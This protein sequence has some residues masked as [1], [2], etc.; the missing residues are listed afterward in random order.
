MPYFAIAYLSPGFYIKVLQE[1]KYVCA[2]THL[3]TLLSHIIFTDVMSQNN[4]FDFIFIQSCYTVP[5][6]QII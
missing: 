5:V 1:Y 2:C 3:H 4:S 6:V